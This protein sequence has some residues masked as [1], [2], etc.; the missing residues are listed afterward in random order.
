MNSFT[1]IFQHRFKPHYAALSPHVSHVLN[2][3]LQQT[4]KST[5]HFLNTCG[6]S[7][8]KRIYPEEMIRES[9]PV[10]YGFYF[11]DENLYRIKGRMVISTFERSLKIF[12]LGWWISLK[13]IFSEINFSVISGY[14]FLLFVV[15]MRILIKFNA[16]F[17]RLK[18][19]F[20]SIRFYNEIS[21][22]MKAHYSFRY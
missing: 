9:F 7:W 13:W 10:S 14:K 8:S 5:L 2:Q 1:G 15:W 3:A 21:S 12:N 17:K 16:V 6:K 20:I 18:I 22:M 19:K 11:W 4:L